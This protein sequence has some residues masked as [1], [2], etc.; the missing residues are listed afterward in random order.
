VSVRPE[1][2]GGTQHDRLLL[3]HQERLR[4]I[5][6]IEFDQMKEI[7]VKDPYGVAAGRLDVRM[8]FSATKEYVLKRKIQVANTPVLQ[9]GW[10]RTW[11][12]GSLQGEQS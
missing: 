12:S 10:T 11:H 7:V 3:F 4:F 9:Q 8:I 5:W 6:I 2:F 1:P